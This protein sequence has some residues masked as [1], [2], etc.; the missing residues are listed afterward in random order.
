MIAAD[1]DAGRELPVHHIPNLGPGAEFYSNPTDYLQRAEIYVSDLEGRDVQR[2]TSNSVYDAEVSVAPDGQG[3]CSAAS[4]R[5]G[6]NSGRPVPTAA[7]R[8]RSRISTDGH[9]LAFTS[10]R[11]A[12]AGSRTTG[13]FLQDISSLHLGPP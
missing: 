2:L 10:T 5:T 6:W 8:Y 11:G 7:T 1:S 4:V 9:W 3:S 12:P 13:I